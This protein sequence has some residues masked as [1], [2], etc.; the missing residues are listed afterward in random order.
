[1]IPQS[2]LIHETTVLRHIADYLGDGKLTS[3]NGGSQEHLSSEQSAELKQYLTDNTLV[4]TTSIVAYVKERYNVCYSIPGMNK[5]LHRNGFSYKKPT[6]VPHKFDAEK[7]QQFVEKYA[8]L[9]QIAGNNVPIL[10]MDAVHPTQSTK[11]SYGWLRKGEKK[12]VETT[13]SR[14]RLNIIG[15]LNLNDIAATIT[16]EYPTINAENFCR[17]L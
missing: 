8:D 11:L 7:Q 10:F 17:F 15:A 12:A 1:M 6:W 4:T 9:K 14:T 3:E 13:R 2:Q 16:R 5:W